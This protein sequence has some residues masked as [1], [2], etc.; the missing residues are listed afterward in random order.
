LRFVAF[1]SLASE[2]F[3]RLV[4]VCVKVFH[5][6]LIHKNSESSDSYLGCPN[7]CVL[8]LNG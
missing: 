5:T 2:C 1:T 6:S 4:D 3:I 8:L 7:F